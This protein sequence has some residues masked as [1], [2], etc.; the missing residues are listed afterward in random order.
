M[1][2]DLASGI[3]VSIVTPTYNRAHALADAY[4]SLLDQRLSL[5]WIVV[6]DGSSDQSLELIEKLSS[7]APF[8][9]RYMRQEHAGK[10]VAINRGVAAARGELV[11]LLDSDDMLTS[12]ALDRLVDHWRS[13]PDRD[14]FVGVTGL[15]I[16]EEGKVIGDLFRAD[17]IDASWQEMIY[18]YR[19]TGDKWGLQRA[20][21]LRANPFPASSGFVIEGTVWRKIGLNYRTRY[22]ND[23]VL[24]VRRS[25]SDRL[26]CRPFSTLAPAI[27]A[28]SR[29]TLTEDIAWF[30]SDPLKFITAA[31]YFS[32]ALFHQN[33]PLKNQ[34]ARLSRWRARTLWAVGS[35]LGWVLYRRDCGRDRR[36]AQRVR[37][38]QLASAPRTP[39]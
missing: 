12:C 5:E 35:P 21:V 4:R 38:S 37:R 32:R 22:V 7:G 6:D 27:S 1:N 20:D 15:D 28:Y 18:H 10:H 9:V 23:V 29:D 13:L 8:P 16:D 34:P 33:V 14:H 17:V 19:V 24:R 2:V 30:P 11:G 31:I 25:G 36:T 39:P 26:S 3:V